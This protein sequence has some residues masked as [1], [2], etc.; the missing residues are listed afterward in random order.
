MAINLKYQLPHLTEEEARRFLEKY[1]PWRVLLEFKSGP[2]SDEYE[3]F[4][5]FN[6]R[7]LFKLEQIFNDIE[8]RAF[9]G[10]VLDIGANRGYNS[11][12]LADTSKSVVTAID[13]DAKHK[14]SVDEL[15]EKMGISIDYKLES[16]EEFCRPEGFDV[17]LLLG[18]LYHLPSPLKA[19]E[20]ACKSLAPGGFI[21]I[22]TVQNA[23]QNPHERAS[24]RHIPG[25]NYWALG[26]GEIMDTLS[27]CGITKVEL[28]RDGRPPQY[29]GKYTRPIY[30]CRKP[31][32]A[33]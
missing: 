28:V 5:P 31:E 24:I 18:V 23:A 26:R 20:L 27:N 13:N 16:A 14:A 6:R 22:E 8:I 2:R 1:A 21:A 30:L 7:P 4:E 17:V 32:A 9:R 15:S 19:L 3:T 11:I 29:E 33:D 12:Y 10:R 25:D